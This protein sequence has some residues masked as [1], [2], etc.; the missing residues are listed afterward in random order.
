MAKSHLDLRPKPPP[1]SVGY[2]VISAVVMPSAA[3]MS[4]R[5][6]PGLCTGAHTSH[7]P[8]FIRAA[9]AGGSMVAW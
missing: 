7:L 1:S 6:A 2:T 9:A 5:A 3:A 4:S 8:W